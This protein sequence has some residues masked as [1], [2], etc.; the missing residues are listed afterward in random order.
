MNV[1]PPPTPGRGVRSNA[2]GRFETFDR[3]AVDDGWDLMEDVPAVRTDVTEE[4]ARS[5]I[6]R[7]TS[8]DI[9]FDRSINPYRG[10]EHGCVYCF[11]RPSHAYLGLSPGLDFETKLIARPN[12]AEVLET[13]LRRPSY[14]CDV[15]AIGTNTDAYQPIERDRRIM[16]DV[17]EVLQ[18]FRH[19]VGIATKGV[20]IERDTDILGEMG[21]AGLARVGISVTTLQAD[22]SR[23]MEPRVPS[24]ARRLRAIE[25]L[26]KAGVPVR[27][28]VSPMVPGLTDHELEAIVDAARDAGAVAA[29]MIPI[30][31]PREVADLWQD[32]LAEHYP[33]RMARVMSKLRDMH[34]GKPYEAEFGKRMRGEGIWADLL[35]Q[36]F[37]RAVRAAG[38][39]TRLPPLRRDLFE[40][41]LAT[42]DQMALF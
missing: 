23:K 33:D 21:Q 26:S 9:S 6:S 5:V 39:A 40:V 37:K 8:P 35:Q 18:R 14:R 11:A 13:E 38:L 1:K 10:C 42:G 36:R 19:P 25:V 27:V 4:V 22:L 31:L 32:W 34:G 20:L 28:M 24:P 16:R 12:A 3:E 2:S 41:P 7:N 29:S 30:R 15:I 17:L